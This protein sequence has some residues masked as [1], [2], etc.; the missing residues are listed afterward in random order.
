[1]T[2][3]LLG[4]GAAKA[5]TTL[6]YNLLYKDEQ[7][8]V[9]KRKEIH[10]FDETPQP[11]R[12]EYDALFKR[13]GGIKLD[14]SPSYMYF[15]G[16]FKTIVELLPTDSFKSVILLRDPVERAISHYRMARRKGYEKLTFEKALAAE[17][18]RI[19]SGWQGY[20]RNSYMVRGLYSNQLQTVFSLVPRESVK[21]FL[22]EDFVKD[23]QSVVDEITDWLGLK[24]IVIS[25]KSANVG[26][27][28][29]SANLSYAIRVM[30]DKAPG[31]LKPYCR[32]VERLVLKLNTDRSGMYKHISPQTRQMLVEYYLDDVRKLRDEYGIDV[33][34]WKNFNLIV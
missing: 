9:G 24:R 29:K 21:I 27:D 5:G 1:M 26:V 33:S 3:Y 2:E 7:F 19:A 16:V 8:N 25:P 31:S 12:E 11:T 23:Q 28:V 4:L 34:K 18:E 13:P 20:K 30:C 32:R 14:I 15:Y 22:F 17:P 6:L 10:Y